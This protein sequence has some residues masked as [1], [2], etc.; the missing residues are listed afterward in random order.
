M[1]ARANGGERAAET[2]AAGRINTY[3]DLSCP[4]I[5]SL[6]G[7]LGPSLGADLGIEREELRHD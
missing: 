2:F 7:P 1:R 6:V 3:G 5:G 4:E